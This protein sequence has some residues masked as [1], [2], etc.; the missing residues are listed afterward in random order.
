MKSQNID[1]HLH[2]IEDLLKAQNLEP[3]S[4]EQASTYLGLSKS[5]LYKL[6]ASNRVPF[7]K[8]N[9]KK[10][11][12]SKTELNKWIFK[13]KIKSDSELKEEAE[14]YLPK[15]RIILK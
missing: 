5:Y 6:T 14:Q 7:Y 15:R 1:A 3:L 11:F 12:F 13:N 9:G 8:P 10:I 4:F 2:K